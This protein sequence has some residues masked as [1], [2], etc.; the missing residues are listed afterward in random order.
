MADWDDACEIEGV[1]VCERCQ[2]IG[3]ACDILKGAGPASSSVAQSSILDIP[4]CD[5]VLYKI[6]R[7][8]LH[9]RQIIGSSPEASVNENDDRVWTRAARQ[10]QFAKL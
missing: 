9:K 3:S 1:W 2:E 5:P 6:L 4:G 10:V 7:Q 8:P